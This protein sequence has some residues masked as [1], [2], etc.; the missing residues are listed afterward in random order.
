MDSQ[1]RS[2][3]G[4]GEL[5]SVD[6]VESLPWLFMPEVAVRPVVP[7][8]VLERFVVPLRIEVPLADGL[9]PLELVMPDEFEFAVE[10]PLVDAL[11]LV[12]FACPC[13]PVEAVPAVWA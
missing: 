13:V 4:A 10:L 2:V 12:P 11:A 9:R 5:E 3:R 6:E 8:M 1:C 7:F